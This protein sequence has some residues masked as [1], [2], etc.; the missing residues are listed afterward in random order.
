MS[1]QVG[2]GVERISYKTDEVRNLSEL[3]KLTGGS[4]HDTLRAYLA[5]DDV[6]QQEIMRL[7]YI[8]ENR[9]SM[10]KSIEGVALGVY[11][12]SCGRAE[13]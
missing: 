11:C 13:I 3:M 12:E 5:H 9:E 2:W 10:M 6:P 7:L 8:I 1:E 4:V